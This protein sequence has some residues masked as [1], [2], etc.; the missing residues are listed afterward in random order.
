MRLMT[1]MRSAESPYARLCALRLGKQTAAERPPPAASSFAH[2]FWRV[3]RV[4]RV[5]R[6]VRVAPGERMAVDAE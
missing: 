1:Q 6:V 4:V 2:A 5:V 3:A